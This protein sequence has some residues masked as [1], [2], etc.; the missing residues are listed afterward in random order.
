LTTALDQLLPTLTFRLTRDDWVAFEGLPVELRGWEALYIYGPLVVCGMAIGWFEDEIR[1]IAPFDIGSLGG[2][3]VL[4]LAA[5][6]VSYLIFAVLINL[7]LWRRVSRRRVL[8]TDTVV[9]AD[10]DGVVIIAGGVTRRHAWADLAVIE[11]AGH[12]FLCPSPGE[13]II[14]PLRA[15]DG[16]EALHLYAHAANELGRQEAG[17]P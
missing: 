17:L 6:V 10:L 2:K 4:G 16:P 8:E 7:R 9:G 5:L 15:F 14:L 11:T 13:P 12:V 1:A 3:L